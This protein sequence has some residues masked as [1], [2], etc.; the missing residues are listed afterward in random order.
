MKDVLKAYAAGWFDSSGYVDV[1]YDNGSPQAHFSITQNE[2]SGMDMLCAAWG[3][4]VYSES[5]THRWRLRQAEIETFLYD[6]RPYLLVKQ[7][8]ADKVL[9]WFSDR[10]SRKAARD[11]TII[12]RRDAG[13]TLQQVAAEVGLSLSRV[14]SLERE[15]RQGA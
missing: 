9:A 3:G 2:R 7:D 10:R 13:A 5:T 15:I 1:L 6:V 12:R 14:H 11:A 8:E 4:T